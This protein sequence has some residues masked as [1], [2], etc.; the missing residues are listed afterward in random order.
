M[1][2]KP[3]IIVALNARLID[4]LTGINQ[5]S[6]HRALVANW[7]YPGLVSYI[8]ERL[9]DE[10]RHYNL[11]LDRILFLEGTPVVG[12]LNLV[13]IGENVP[14]MHEFDRTAEE[15][16]VQAYNENIELCRE[17]KDDDTRRRLESILADETDHLHDLEANLKQIEQMTLANYLSAKI[18]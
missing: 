9:D 18:V 7:E 12:R 6:V 14:Q 16:I 11:L 3:E 8:Q 17:L 2:G 10:V 15:N 1:K 5:Y 4:E 13:T